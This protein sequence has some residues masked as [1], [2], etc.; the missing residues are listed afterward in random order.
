MRLG[1]AAAQREG[2]QVVICGTLTVWHPGKKGRAGLPGNH[3]HDYFLL[4]PA[5]PFEAEIANW[6]VGHNG[7]FEKTTLAE[8]QVWGAGGLDDPALK[9][10]VG[11]RV[12]VKGEL[13]AALTTQHITPLLIDL[14][15]GGTCAPVAYCRRHRPLGFLRLRVFRPSFFVRALSSC[16]RIRTSIAIAAGLRRRPQVL[17]N[18]RRPVRIGHAF[19]PVGNVLQRRS[20]FRVEQ[21]PDCMLVLADQSS[22]QRI[23]E[24]H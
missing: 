12:V 1:G 3:D 6:D 8:I 17:V 9:R 16:D 5:R 13:Q 2:D 7:E 19:G 21:L 20:H 18:L 15:D 24:T 22:R 11:K 10:L 14:Q 4:K 23:G